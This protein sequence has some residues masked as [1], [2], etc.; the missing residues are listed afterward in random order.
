MR[1]QTDQPNPALEPIG[2]KGR[3]TLA[4]LGVLHKNNTEV[5]YYEKGIRFFKIG[6]KSLC[7]TP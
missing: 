3:P 1:C 4:Q 7:E 5:S 6:K 2:G